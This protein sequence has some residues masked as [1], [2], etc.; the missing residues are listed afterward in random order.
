MTN[1]SNQHYDNIKD[2][3]AIQNALT[4]SDRKGLEAVPYFL[5]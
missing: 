4:F 1:L 2:L 5:K 3:R